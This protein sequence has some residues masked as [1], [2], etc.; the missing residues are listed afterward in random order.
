MLKT[1][2]STESIL[3]ARYNKLR[4]KRNKE[5]P[6]LVDAVPNQDRIALERR[7]LEITLRRYVGLSF[8]VFFSKSCNELFAKIV[9]NAK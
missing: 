5:F 9:R 1:L 8:F 2:R 3:T 6:F 7:D 4:E